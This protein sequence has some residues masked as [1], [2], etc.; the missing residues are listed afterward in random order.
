MNT[1]GARLKELRQQ[2]GLSLRE[3]A[4]QAHMSH[5]FIAD[6][7]AGRS[8]PSLDTLQALAKALNVSVSF[9]IEEA[10]SQENKNVPLWERDEPPTEIELEEF[11]RQQNFNLMIG[12]EPIDEETKQDLLDF[13]RFLIEKKRKTAKG[14]KK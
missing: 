5:S 1:V 10:V 7:E 8:T 4:K 9:L 6:I 3:L 12:G 11:L 2:K 13:A 14:D